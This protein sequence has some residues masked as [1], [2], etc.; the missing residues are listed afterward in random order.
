M[1]QQ[2]IITMGG[3]HRWKKGETGNAKGR[4][5]GARQRISEK[6]LADLADVWR[7]CGPAVLRKLASEEPGKLATIA[8]GLL[9]KD[10][11]VSVAQTAPGG[12]SPED[13][14]QLR[15]V[16]DAI[17]AAGLGDVPPGE[18]FAGIETYLR[19]E[20]A[21]PVLAIQH[22][23]AQMLPMETTALPPPPYR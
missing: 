2:D 19:S 17:E 4:P 12:L 20:F 6:L 5:V 8:F 10:V 16:L 9:P 15:G 13:Y 23:P 21:K 11:F 7:E 18:L 1:N 14:A 22:A 3:P